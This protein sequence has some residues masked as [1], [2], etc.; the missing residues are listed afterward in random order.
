MVGPSAERSRP[1]RHPLSRVLA[2]GGGVGHTDEAGQGWQTRNPLPHAAVLL[3]DEGEARFVRLEPLRLRT[4]GARL[5]C[6]SPHGGLG[7]LRVSPQPT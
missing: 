5:G 2:S 4:G 3:D 6:G 1:H 7:T